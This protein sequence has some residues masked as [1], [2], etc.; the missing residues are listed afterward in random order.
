MDRIP[1]L[2]PHAE[3]I[4]GSLVLVSPRKLFHMKAVQLLVDAL[5]RQA[6]RDLFRVRREMSV[7]LDPRQR[8]EPDVLV[9]HAPADIGLDETW[10]P[11]EAVVLAAEVVSP[12]SLVRDRERK[13]KLYSEAGI[14]H[15]W[16]VENSDGK[17]VLYAYELDPATREYVA[18]GIFHERVQL[19]VPFP[20]DI[21]LSEI[22]R[23]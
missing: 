17:V 2:P 12:D 21:D 18:L 3:L 11:A 9:V 14:R 8:P 6:P 15:F 10:Y 5:T 1:D 23:I 22:D 4:D 7:V 19:P 20:I 16:R 13:P